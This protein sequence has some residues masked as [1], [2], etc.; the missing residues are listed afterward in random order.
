VVYLVTLPMAH[1]F[2]LGSPGVLGTLMNGGRV[3]MI[4]SPRP[5]VAFAAVQTERV[6]HS[7][8]V[9]AIGQRW[10]DAARAGSWDLSSLRTVQIGG[11]VL[12][13][14]LVVRLREAL[15]CHVQQVYGM[16]EG[17]LNYTRAD[18]PDDVVACT[19][20]RPICPDD[21]LLIVDEDGSPVPPGSPGELLT[22]GPYT[23]R[24]Y[25]RAAEHNAVAYTPDGWYRTGDVVRV[26]PSGNLVVETRVK[27]LV[28][29]GGEKVSGP[30][31]ET[32]ALALP[33]VRQA[34]VVPTP[35]PALGERVCLC[36]V[37][38]AGES[39]TLAQVQQ[40]F[41]ARGVARYK[42]PERLEVFDEFP[43]TPIGKVDKKALR[44]LL[45]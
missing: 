17:L 10:A 42:T 44:R 25:F 39:L 23:P 18:D 13:D 35:D 45:A 7:P 5:Q 26:H 12:P 30:E 4:G 37:P 2:P 19:Q 38:H 14:G 21:E 3:V 34:A 16:A 11:S 15:G 1:N 28:Y 43:L 41:E 20:G 29:R 24:G 27:D 6:T 40:S 33:Q 32:L 8:L 9:P 36:V 22:R 31:V